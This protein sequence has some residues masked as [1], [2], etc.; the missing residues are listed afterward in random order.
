M[1]SRPSWW[2]STAVLR[3]RRPY[4]GVPAELGARHCPS[5][6]SGPR[7]RTGPS[8]AG[9]P[10]HGSGRSPAPSVAASISCERECAGSSLTGAP[11]ARRSRSPS[12]A[13]PREARRALPGRPP[14]RLLAGR[15]ARAGRSG[16][17]RRAR[18]S[19]R[20]SA[21]SHREPRRTCRSVADR[22]SVSFPLPPVPCGCDPRLRHPSGGRPAFE[23]E[24]SRRA[25]G[26]R[27]PRA[28]RRRPVVP[29]A[30]SRRWIGPGPER[31]CRRRSRWP[32]ESRSRSLG[33]RAPSDAHTGPG[34]GFPGRGERRRAGDPR[35]AGKP[36]TAARPP[37][38]RRIGPVV[39][40][41]VS[42]GSFGPARGTVEAQP[43]VAERASAGPI[44]CAR[45]PGRRGRFRLDRDR[46]ELVAAGRTTGGPHLRAGNRPIRSAPLRPASCG[47]RPRGRR[48]WRRWWEKRT[49]TGDRTAPLWPFEGRRNRR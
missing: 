20:G 36:D 39:V 16:R 14:L 4:R 19:A 18:G 27:R 33:P 24:A 11:G 2:R 28:D 40:P 45:A 23:R 12:A 42:S 21:G 1:S 32:G 3:V 10:R 6:P 48:H 49:P 5:P 41:R 13:T 15:S 38:R 30:C 25:V 37:A 43:H 9:Q 44:P 35:A 8:N 7:V 46:P 29:S 47:D 26:G 22:A 31:R 34:G 17:T